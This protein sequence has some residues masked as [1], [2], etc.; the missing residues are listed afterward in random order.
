MKHRGLNIFALSGAAEYGARVAACLNQELAE[1]EERTFED[2]EHKVRPLQS[3]RNSDTYVLQ[4]FYED[5]RQSL[6][7][8]FCRLL[9]FIGALKEAKAASV[10]VVAPYLCY[11]RKD[12]QTKSRDPV[13]TRYVAQLLEAVGCD[14]IVTMDVHNLS[15]YQNAFRIPSEHLEAAPLFA[16][17]FADRAK[18]SDVVVVSPD[19]GGVKRARRF[20]ELLGQAAGVEPPPL[21]FAEKHRSGGVVS[22]AGFSGSVEGRSAI[23]VDDLIASGGTL[24]RTAQTCRR[25]GARE[26]HAAATHGLFVGDAS[27]TLSDPVFDSVLV[28]DTL[29]P[30][31]LDP[32][33]VGKPVTILDTA[34][35]V[36]EAIRRIDA[37]ESMESLPAF[38][39][40]GSA[41]PRNAGD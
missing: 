6:A 13:T 27:E 23:I 22:G 18:K 26:I 12:R 5:A 1:H 11:S 19:A 10:T 28:T 41:E 3:V 30:A 9:F 24:L 40:D 38:S 35:L 31:R 16:R 15:A 36:A 33:L 39:L 29:P 21:A 25:L 34:P 4:A 2:G 20:A 37:G 14:R 7:E 32:R 8:R 17:H